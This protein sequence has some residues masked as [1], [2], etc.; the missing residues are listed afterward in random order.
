[1][2]IQNTGF[3]YLNSVVDAG[4]GSRIWDYLNTTNLF[5]GVQ[6]RDTAAPAARDVC[7][8]VGANLYSNYFD[9]TDINGIAIPNAAT[10]V[11]VVVR[12]AAFLTSGTTCANYT[13]DTTVQL[14]KGGTPQGNNKALGVCMGPGSDTW[15][16]FDYGGS[17]D[18]WGLNLSPGDINASNFGVRLQFLG[19]PNALDVKLTYVALNIYYR[20]GGI[21]LCL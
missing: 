17:S 1:M 19:G 16:D 5:T 15:E 14:I 12:Y 2:S 10:I 6:V 9:L 3:N 18:L 4:G 21:L 7:Y 13:K 8:A 11:G 20:L